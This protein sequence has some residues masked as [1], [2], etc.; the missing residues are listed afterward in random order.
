MLMK[1][2]KKLFA[3]KNDSSFQMEVHSRL[4]LPPLWSLP[5]THWSGTI[6]LNDKK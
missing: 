1:T 5:V 3:A 6:E 2:K 4:F